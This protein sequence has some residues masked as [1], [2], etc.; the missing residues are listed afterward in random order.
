MNGIADAFGSLGTGLRHL[1]FGYDT[2][3]NA[4]DAQTQKDINQ[5]Q[6]NVQQNEAQNGGVYNPLQPLG[7]PSLGTIQND[8]EWVLIA[9]VGL[10]AYSF[11]FKK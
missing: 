5:A 9:L 2:K 3:N 6:Q 11:I 8:L 7:I 1:F 10:L 4:Q